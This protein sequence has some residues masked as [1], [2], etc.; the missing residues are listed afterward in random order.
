MAGFDAF[1][2]MA[3]IDAQDKASAI[4][5]RVQAVIDKFKE[6]MASAAETASAAGEEIDASLLQT[7]SGA[8]AL[9]L[10]NDRVAA[11]ESKVAL[12][13][14]D[15]AAAEQLLMDA[16]AT[17]SSDKE[18]VAGL[19]LLTQASRDAAKA[20]AELKDAQEAQTLIARAAGVANDELAVSEEA[21]ATGASGSV[22]LVL[23]AGAALVG[24]GALAVKAAGDFQ[25]AT[26]HLVTDAGENSNAIKGVSQAMLDMSGQVGLSAEKLAQGMYHIESTGYHAAKGGLD[27]LRIA[28][29][30]AKVG[31]ADLDTVSHALAGTM[32]SY[33][34]KA[35]DAAKFMDM[36]IET[37]AQGDLRMQD[38]VTTLGNVT[39]IAAA[40][41][42]SFD[43][44]GGAI[45]TMTSQN[46]TAAQA[47]ENLSNFI[48]HLSKPTDVMRTAMVGLGIDA[49]DVS[50]NLGKRG[51]TGT[52]D[53]LVKAIDD[54][55]HSGGIFINT[56]QDSQA[57]AKS[58]NEM[59]SQM[60]PTLRDLSQQMLDGK[61]GVKDYTD[62]VKD[63][64]P[65]SVKQASQ[66]KMLEERMGSF[67]KLLSSGSGDSETFNAALSSV[68]GGQIGLRTALMLSTDGGNKFA[69]AAKAIADSGNE[70]SGKVKN[71]D[72]IQQ[73]FNQK[74][75]QA[76]ASFDALGIAVGQKVLPYVQKLIEFLTPAFEWFTKNKQAMDGLAVVIG[77]PLLAALAAILA[78][79]ALVGA[80]I[81]AIGYVVDWLREG[82]HK[83][84]SWF[85]D[86]KDTFVDAWDYV[87]KK[88]QSI[89]KWFDDNVLKWVREQLA[90][91]ISWWHSHSKEIVEVWDWVWK[92]AVDT[93]KVSWD[94]IR[95]VLLILAGFW[96]FA[97]GTIKDTLKLV[98]DTIKDVISISL[99]FIGDLIGVALDLITG[100]WGKAWDDT[101]KLAKD[102][103]DG[104]VNFFEGVGKDLGDLLFD[105]G[106]NAIKGLI[107]GMKAM[108]GGLV[109]TVHDITQSIKDFFQ[110]SPAKRGPFAGSGSM[111]N[112]GSNIGKLLASGMSKS[113]GIVTS[114]AMAMAQSASP[115]VGLGGFGLAGGAGGA[116]GGGGVVIFDLRGSQV[117]SDR[118]MDLLVDKIGRQIATRLLPAGGVRIRS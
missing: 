10:A 34:A 53:V 4:F 38:L 114:A 104:L 108:T 32:E 6:S 80:A 25:S 74:L 62:A 33:G 17:G 103:W 24:T 67:N 28:A 72:A 113:T 93:T 52:L 56:L 35:G 92:F 58:A 43:Q 30:G 47:T 107:N 14:R 76:K 31:N 115:N 46:M 40:A 69:D 77:G 18:L 65:T 22:G 106:K 48:Q 9:A 54:H 11:A 12:A 51:L 21:A 86:N 97:W 50:E 7:A 117:T 36:L 78:I 61:L 73:T 29:E 99:K 45:A 102:A 88:F 20:T 105:A 90:Y 13:T 87:S 94:I 42:I 71:W 96:D 75:D 98:W 81:T 68:T 39:P 49:N 27:V 41:G 63:M 5:E 44:V 82:F 66:F 89:A 109:S 23:A 70:A 110:W 112:A 83:L 2:V 116:G 100:K 16:R 64:D 59:L 95:T 91:L 84:I 85:N 15:Q 79:G 60:S 19:D 8:D 101:K 1:T 57:A 111:E 3:I 118:D 26:T 55:N 37:T